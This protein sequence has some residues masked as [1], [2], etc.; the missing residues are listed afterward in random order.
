MLHPLKGNYM[1]S[2]GESFFLYLPEYIL[3][4][5]SKINAAILSQR[6]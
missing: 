2:K 1:L 6:Q 5:T 4:K 3:P